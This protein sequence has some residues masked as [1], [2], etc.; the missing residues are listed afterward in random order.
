MMTTIDT[1]RTMM[2][3]V[4]DELL[5]MQADY[6]RTGMYQERNVGGFT[7]FVGCTTRGAF[8]VECMSICFDLATDCAY[9]IYQ[10]QEGR[11]QPC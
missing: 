9:H 4:L 6:N 3:S 10:R 7:V 11:Y 5:S 1:G 2:K 8:Q